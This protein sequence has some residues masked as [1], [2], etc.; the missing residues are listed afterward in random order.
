MSKDRI[1][2]R[3]EELCIF[4]NSLSV[5]VEAQQKPQAKL[6]VSFDVYCAL[7][8]YTV[9]LHHSHLNNKIAIEDLL[10]SEDLIYETLN[11]SLDVCVDFFLPADS[12]IIG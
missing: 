7:L 1:H 11:H 3:G 12:M 5:L 6:T 8:E 10:F 2:D 4:I 9:H